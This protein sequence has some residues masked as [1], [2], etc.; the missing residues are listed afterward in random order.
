MT[1]FLRTVILILTVCALSMTACGGSS[2][3]LKIPKSDAIAVSIN[4][5]GG[6]KLK[7]SSELEEFTV[8]KNGEVLSDGGIIFNDLIEIVKLNLG[9]D[10]TTKIDEG[11]FG[12][13]EYFFYRSDDVVLGT[14]VSSKWIYVIKIS[15]SNC[16]INLVNTTSQESA[17]ECFRQLTFAKNNYNAL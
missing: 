11:S 5:S 12:G 2:C 3:T 15:D 13:N 16:G 14:V 7:K 6:F 8:E 10:D 4:T 9:Y 17:E 1:K